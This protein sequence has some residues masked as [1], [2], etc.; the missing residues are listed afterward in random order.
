MIE[1]RQLLP[2]YAYTYLSAARSTRVNV[3]LEDYKLPAGNVHN[4]HAKEYRVDL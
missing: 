3:Q 1:T 2:T 4:F